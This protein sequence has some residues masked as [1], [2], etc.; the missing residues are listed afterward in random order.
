MLV[1]EKAAYR[2]VVNVELLQR[3]VA[4]EIDRDVVEPIAKVSGMAAG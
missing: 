3:A 1:K 2:V 4:V